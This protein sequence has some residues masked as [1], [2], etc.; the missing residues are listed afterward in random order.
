MTKS[1]QETKLAELQ[2]EI[3]VI[4]HEQTTVEKYLN[5][6]DNSITKIADILGDVK[7]LVTLHDN[8]LNDY[9]EDFSELKT[10]VT[11]LK[12][13]LLRDINLTKV[14][15]ERRFK[16]LEVWQYMIIGGS[17]IVGIF[18]NTLFQNIVHR[19]INPQQVNIQ[20]PANTPLPTIIK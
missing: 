20:Q 17:I 8:K 5:K 10:I 4:K 6:F 15:A 16:R 9:H 11:N 2:T 7:E 3:T 13:D 1:Q 12:S 14:N 18:M 19:T